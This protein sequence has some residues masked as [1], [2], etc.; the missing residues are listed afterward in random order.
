MSWRVEHADPLCLL[1]ELPDGLAQTCFL[2]PPSDLPAPEALAILVQARR[3]VRDEGTLWFSRP[4]RASRQQELQLVERAGW[5]GHDRA[6]RGSRGLPILGHAALTLWT[7]QPNFHINPRFRLSG[8]ALWRAQTLCPSQRSQPVSA[9]QLKRAAW[10]VPVGG[11]GAI[12]T[13]VIDWCLRSSTSPR[14]C[15]ICGAPW[16]RLAGASDRRGRWRPGCSHG[17][18]GGRCL[19]LDPFCEHF[20]EVGLAALRAG[21]SYLGAAEDSATAARARARL[22]AIEQVARG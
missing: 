6:L 17:N 16:R 1:S 4:G 18:G 22:Q 3:V 12:S 7:K 19:V 2:R 13:Q 15:G 8:S 5:L 21:R 10:Y 14:A 11:G 20:A 9:R